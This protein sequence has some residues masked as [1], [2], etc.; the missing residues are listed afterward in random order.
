MAPSVRREYPVGAALRHRAVQRNR[1]V[2]SDIESE[3]H[4]V[5]FSSTSKNPM[6]VDVG[7]ALDDD[8]DNA[9]GNPLSAWPPTTDFPMSLV[10][11]P[12]RVDAHNF[13]VVPPFAVS[14]TSRLHVYLRLYRHIWPSR[15]RTGSWRSLFY[16]TGGRCEI[17]GGCP[18]PNAAAPWFFQY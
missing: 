1:G 10:V 5:T 7:E 9:N 2:A 18:S 14:H 13:A 15:G 8:D 12:A 6:S 3:R 4:T 11:E 16:I 17:K